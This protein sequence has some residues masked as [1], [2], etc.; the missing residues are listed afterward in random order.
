MATIS[1]E[2]RAGSGAPAAAAETGATISSWT[3]AN[4]APL[5]LC[6]FGLTTF[7]LS[8]INSNIVSVTETPVVLG[9]AFAYGGLAQLLAGMWEFR[10][11][12]TFGAVAFSSYGA[13]WISFF[14]LVTFDA[15][16]I[17]NASQAGSAVGLYLW[18]W[19]IITGMFFLCTFAA[20][21]S[22]QAVF[23][24]LTITFVCLGIGNAG[25]STNMIH[26]GGFVGIANAAAALYAACADIMKS[27]YGHDVL[28]VG[29]PHPRN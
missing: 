29:A 12:N 23:L 26:I 2:P 3:V 8:M 24:L 1:S 10:N 7:V 9:M 20:P 6:G 18:V 28:P 13:F 15:K 27:V 25:A 22:I 14:F 5:G 16:L 4:P 17:T 19:G 21:R 11:G